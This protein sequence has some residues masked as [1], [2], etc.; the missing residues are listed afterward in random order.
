MRRLIDH[1]YNKDTEQRQRHPELI[2]FLLHSQLWETDCRPEPPTRWLATHSRELMTQVR[3]HQRSQFLQEVWIIIS[4]PTGCT[5]TARKWQVEVTCRC[6]YKFP[7]R[8]GMCRYH[9]TKSASPCFC[10]SFISLFVWFESTQGPAHLP[11]PSSP[12]VQSA[13]PTSTRTLVWR[14]VLPL[15]FIYPSFHHLPTIIIRPSIIQLQLLSIRHPS[16]II[17]PLSYIFI[18]K[19]QQNRAIVLFIHDFSIITIIII[20]IQKKKKPSLYS[21]MTP[22]LS[23]SLNHSWGTSVPSQS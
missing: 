23:S 8:L 3:L 13:S 17:H 2:R 20:I 5:H 9:R 1:K 22:S 15:S 7:T 11:L 14:A 12:H 6:I 10:L 19:I 18:I 16:F 21:F 4:T